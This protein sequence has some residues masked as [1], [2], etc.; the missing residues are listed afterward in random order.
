MKSRIWGTGF[1]TMTLYLL[2]LLCLCVT[3]WLKPKWLSFHTLATRFSALW[4]IFPKLKMASKEGDLMISPLLKQN[5]GMEFPICKKHTPWNA[6]NNGVV[7][8]T[9]CANPKETALYETNLIIRWSVIVTEIWFQSGNYL[10]LN[11]HR[12][13]SM[14]WDDHW[15]EPGMKIPRKLIINGLSNFS[16][17]IWL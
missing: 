3:F 4:L 8:G 11:A 14:L 15:K 17:W 5:Y 6:L 7:T 9:H 2:G 10:T 1:S 13:I 12:H 16:E